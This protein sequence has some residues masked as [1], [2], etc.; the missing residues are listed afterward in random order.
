MGMW[1][2]NKE[3][4]G[5]QLLR[6][7]ETD[8]SVLQDRLDRVK[9]KLKLDVF[10]IVEDNWLEEDY[11][12]AILKIQKANLSDETIRSVLREHR[13]DLLWVVVASGLT[14]VA[15]LSKL[16]V[17]TIMMVA[18]ILEWYDRDDKRQIEPLVA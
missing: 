12:K 13:E 7:S 4:V 2:D 8:V 11:N 3:A 9:S 6:Q 17:E 18:Y 5:E 1:L 14:T 16:K 15:A 10:S